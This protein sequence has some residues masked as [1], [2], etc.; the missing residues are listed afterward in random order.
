MTVVRHTPICT[1]CD[2]PIAEAVYK[3]QRD[4]NNPVFGDSFSHWEYLDHECEGQK[5]FQELIAMNIK[6]D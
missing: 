5:K 3:P 2:E 4:E 6:W 1:F